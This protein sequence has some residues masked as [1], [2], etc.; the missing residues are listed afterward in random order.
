MAPTRA[1]DRAIPYYFSPFPGILFRS[2]ILI[3]FEGD[4][5]I[6]NGRRYQC[7]YFS[8]VKVIGLFV[9]MQYF[10]YNLA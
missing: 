2:K 5:S 7:Q 9:F 1:I 10:R 4:K 6:C 3:F 8:R